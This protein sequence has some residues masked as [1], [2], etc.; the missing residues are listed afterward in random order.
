MYRLLSERIPDLELTLLTCNHGEA[1]EPELASIFGRVIQL[2][3]DAFNEA[4]VRASGVLG[5]R[6]DAVDL[7]FLQA[8]DLVHFFRRS[9]VARVVVSPM[10]LF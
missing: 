2:P 8:G 6:V 7:V 9:G 1:L 5:D 4:G 10:E 3:I